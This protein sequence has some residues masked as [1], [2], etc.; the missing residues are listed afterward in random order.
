MSP[1]AQ[2]RPDPRFPALVKTERKARTEAPVATLGIDISKQT[3]NAHLSSEKGEA[4]K[5]FPNSI[6]GFKQLEAWLRNRKVDRAAVCMEATGS[7]WEALALHLTEAGHPVSVV[8]PARIKA[9]AQSELLRAKTDA[10]DAALIARFAQAQRPETWVPPAPETRHLQALSR[11]VE[12]LRS[13]RAEEEVR[14][15]IPGLPVDVERSTREI[16]VKLDQEIKR[17]EE[18]IEDHFDQHP[19]LKSKRDLLVSIPGIGRQTASSI[20]AEIPKIAEFRSSKAVAAFAG[21]TPKTRESGASIRG[22]GHICKTGNARL[23]KALYMPALTARRFNASLRA[24]GDRLAA[25]GKRR[26]V[27]IVAIMRKMLVL[28]YGVLRSG[29]PFEAKAACA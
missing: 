20:L 5:S 21:L 7:Y 2:A 16:I 15:Q 29:R 11:H 6:V 27:I 18:L 19:N 14:L 26:M 1:Y 13:R 24:F 28:A 9:Y 8:N 23:R 10:V 3:F 22:R 4:K 17:T 25:A 12:H